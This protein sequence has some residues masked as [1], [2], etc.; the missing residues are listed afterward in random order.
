MTSIVRTLTGFAIRPFVRPIQ[1]FMIKIMKRVRQPDD[2]RPI[3][4]ASEYLINEILLPSTF[5][6][7]NDEEFREK[8]NFSKLPRSEHDRIFNELEVVA[9]CLALFYIHAVE[10][11]IKMSDYRFWNNVAEHLPKQLQH[12]LTGYGVDSGNAKLMRELIGMRKE[13]YQKLADK[14][15]EVSDEHMAEFKTLPPEMKSVAAAVQATAVGTADHIRRGKLSKKDPLVQFL[16]TWL[17]T[18]R[19][20]VHRFVRHL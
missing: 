11:L 6:V 4:A 3:I 12:I 8:A 13:E 1:Y 18:L 14:M 2:N 10:P 17:M 19:K 20:N 5:K 7:F 16:I 9:V 15:Y